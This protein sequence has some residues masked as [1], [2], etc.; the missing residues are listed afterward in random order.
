M[1]S[2][3][4]PG[5]SVTRM[6][7]EWSDGDL[8]VLDQLLPIVHAELHRQAHA[9]IRRERP[10]HTLQTTALI[11][12]AFI[13]LIDQKTPDLESRTHFFAIA[14]NAMR[15][16]LIDYARAK[17]RKKRGGNPIKLTLDEKTAVDAGKSSIDLF[18]LDEALQRLEEIYPQQVKV[19]ELRYFSGM[20][21]E[22]TAEVMGLSRSTVAREWSM[23]KAWL[24]RELTRRT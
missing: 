9:Y 17:N 6:L 7:R 13:K 8:E 4:L 1:A 16:V 21:L 14:A 15:Q 19:V 5:E 11:N 12:E 22:E 3:D 18:A 2:S 10:G 23:A 20:T 24:Y